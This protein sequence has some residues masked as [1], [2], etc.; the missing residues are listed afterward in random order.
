MNVFYFLINVVVSF[1]HKQ[2]CFIIYLCAKWLCIVLMHKPTSPLKESSTHLSICLGQIVG[3]CD[4]GTF[5]FTSI[6]LVAIVDI[7]FAKSD[8]QLRR[9]SLYPFPSGSAAPLLAAPCLFR[10]IHRH[11]CSH[12]FLA[13][14]N[15]P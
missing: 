4:T 10:D 1:C 7:A 8:H 15:N 5:V 13:C 6:P 3:E 14:Q 9:W 12:F 11:S 2:R